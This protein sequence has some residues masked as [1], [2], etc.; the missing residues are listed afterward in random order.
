M[1]SSTFTLQYTCKCT[2]L[3]GQVLILY[4]YIHAYLWP[5]P[6]QTP[7]FICVRSTRKEER[8]QFTFS[9]TKWCSGKY[10]LNLLMPYTTALC[11]ILYTCR[12]VYCFRAHYSNNLAFALR[13]KV[14]VYIYMR[15]SD[16]KTQSPHSLLMN[17]SLHLANHVL[18]MEVGCSPYSFCLCFCKHLTVHLY[19]YTCTC[20]C[21]YMYVQCTC[22]SAALVHVGKIV[23]PT[24]LM[25]ISTCHMYI[26][27]C[28]I[29]FTMRVDS[30]CMYMYIN[31]FFVYVHVTDQWDLLLLEILP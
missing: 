7:S 3:C 20:T 8:G 29:T 25:Y 30:I 5:K 21:I 15:R 14:H 10:Y 16:D 13:A 22:I 1:T 31:K 12:S 9:W 19:L 6:G 23:W 28:S 17:W 24:G 4:V 2:V 27:H 18:W 11:N 26:L